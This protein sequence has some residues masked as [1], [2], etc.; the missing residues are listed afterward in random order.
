[1]D[2]NTELKRFPN[3]LRR[4]GNIGLLIGCLS[5]FHCGC[6]NG[7][8]EPADSIKARI[9]AVS[10]TAK[11]VTNATEFTELINECEAILA[12]EPP[13]DAHRNYLKKLLAW[14][15]DKRGESRV[16][17]ADQFA[18]AD[19]QQQATLVR[20][21]AMT[22][23]NRSIEQDPNRWQTR[24]HR[25]SLLASQEDFD[26]AIIDYSAVITLN[27]ETTTAWF[28]R[29][30][31]QSHLGQF[32]AAAADYTEVLKR[33]P[34]D[35]Q[36]RSGR[37]HCRL[38]ND[39]W[40]KALQD[41]DTV[42]QQAP[43]DAWAYANRADAYLAMQNWPKAKADLRQAL[44]LQT[45]G[46]FYRRLAWLLATCPDE[47]ICDGDK[48]LEMAQ[49]AVEISGESKLT[50][51]TLAASYAAAGNFDR[52]RD[53]HARVIAMAN[54]DDPETAIKQAAYQNNERYQESFDR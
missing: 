25:A 54:S 36:A 23:F 52:A 51:D 18:K 32:E 13:S 46:E 21:E 15:L 29:A 26:K 19:S 42:S 48:A 16:E 41:Y 2:S 44:D 43:R 4:W 45:N 37:G 11:R 5:F 14:T 31:I 8:E 12:L 3:A 47:S 40:L 50:L 30:E 33:D 6:L 34:Q 49:R 27:P 28:N 20:R 24:L 35:I 53:V 10:Q 39:Q 7:Q 1:M 22:D 17:L 9:Q 38:A